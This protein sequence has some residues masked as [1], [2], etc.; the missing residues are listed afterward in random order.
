MEICRYDL[1]KDADRLSYLDVNLP[2]YFERNGWQETHRRCGW[3]YL[4]LSPRASSI[5]ASLR[6]GDPL[7]HL[8]NESIKTARGLRKAG[9]ACWVQELDSSDAVIAPSV[10][11][12]AGGGSPRASQSEPLVGLCSRRHR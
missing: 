5:V 4:R 9:E 3:G 12:A 11:R 7:G 1:L 8:V 6:G 2:L 10:S